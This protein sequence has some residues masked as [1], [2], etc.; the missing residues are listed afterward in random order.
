M[1]LFHTGASLVYVLVVRCQ[2]EQRTRRLGRAHN[3]GV[4]SDLGA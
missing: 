2:S 1:P 4:L 3:L